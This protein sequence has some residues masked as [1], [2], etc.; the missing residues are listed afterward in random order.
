MFLG[1]AMS[2]FP[3]T[4]FAALVVFLALMIGP[5]TA[6]ELS[7]SQ[8]YADEQAL[9]TRLSTSAVVDDQRQ[10]AAMLSDGLIANAEN[11][12]RRV[13]RDGATAAYRRARELGDQSASTTVALAR[14]L[15][16]DTKGSGLSELVS[17]LRN[18]MLQGNGD[19]AYILALDATQNQRLPKNKTVPMLQAAA[20]MGSIPAVLDLAGSND[21]TVG[22]T[23]KSALLEK[24]EQKAQA[25]VAPAAFA[26]YQ[27]YNDNKF[28]ARDPQKA[29]GWLTQAVAA[30]HVNAM[31]RY[32]AHLQFGRDMPADPARALSFFREAAQAGSSIA[33]MTLGRDSRSHAPMG[34]GVE[35]SRTWLRRAAEVGIRGAAIEIV[36]LDLTLALQETDP[37][38]KAKM[39]EAALQPIATDPAALADFASRHW[40]KNAVSVVDPVLRT[41]LERQALAGSAT[42]GLAYDAWLKMDGERLPDQVARA[43]VKSLHESP[44]GSIGFANFTIADLALDKRIGSTVVSHDEAMDLLFDAAGADVGQAMLRLGQMYARGDQVARSPIFAQRW[45]LQAQKQAVERA[46]WEMAD[47]QAAS[48]DPQQLEIAE[49]FYL[50]KLDEGDPRAALALVEHRVTDGTLDDSMLM[51]AKSAAAEPHDAIALAKILMAGGNAESLDAAEAILR[52]LAEEQSEPEALTVYGRLLVTRARSPDDVQH[53]FDVLHLAV[54]SGRSDA[55]VV[56][57]A[58]YLSSAIY[59]ESRSDAIALLTDVLT[60]NPRDANARLVMSRAYL[61]G[62]GVKRD[63]VKAAELLA[64][65]SD[66]GEYDLPKASLLEAD[67]LAFS[68]SRRNPEAAVAMLSAQAARGSAAAEQALGRTYLSGFGISLDPDIAAG[69]LYTAAHAGDKAAMAAFGHLVLNGYGVSQSQQG[70]LTWLDRAADA[71]STSAMYE[72][73]RIYALGSAGDIDQKLA[74]EWL[75]KAANRNHPNAAYE[76]GL[77]YLKGEWVPADTVQAAA[78][79]ERSANAGSLLAG[80][81]LEIVKRQIAEGDHLDASGASEE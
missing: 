4:V 43:L 21:V 38:R 67:W 56:L 57:A 8:R 17:A 16:R 20:V 77:A 29:I 23:T 13:D 54:N 31:E 6:Q 28:V 69:H 76:L 66:V 51:Q 55:K 11:P 25:G 40:Q 58:T 37:D 52:P 61:L 64:S 34:V 12:L 3:N 2:N 39:V 81:T 60:E 30:G 15:L 36:G 19:A 27:I 33:A 35:E 5:S 75:E 48:D 45:F 72:L 44:P 73:S 1:A 68:S 10:L 26:L 24:L 18:Y 22:D 59:S 62:L 65:I 78:W 80:R 79:F 70:G 50:Q 32:A 46:S 71:G 41:L 49:R 7:V 42:A 47:M 74:M 9:M 63:P 53:G 14:L